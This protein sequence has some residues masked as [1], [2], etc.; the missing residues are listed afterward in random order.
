MPKI[1]FA[2]PLH[3]NLSDT[4]K[5]EL[6]SVGFEVI[7]ISFYGRK[8]TYTSL[9][10]R[11]INFLYKITGI[12]T[13]YKNHLIFRD[14]AN[15]IKNI[16]NDTGQVD[17]CFIIR[18]DVFPKEILK[19]AIEKASKSVAYQ[20]DGLNV[21][22]NTIDKINLFD[23]FYVF[24]KADLHYTNTKLS[25]NFYPESFKINPDFKKSD[26]YYTGTLN[27]SR[28]KTLE[29]IISTAEKAGLNVL[30]N[31]FFPKETNTKLTNLKTTKTYIDYSTNL[32]FV[33]NT[34]IVIDVLNPTH[35]G[36]SFRTFEAIGFKKKLITNNKSIQFY[37]FYHPNN[38]LIWD[39]TQNVDDILNFYNCPYIPLDEN[40]HAKYGFKNW[41]N[42][43]LDIQPH[44]SISNNNI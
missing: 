43:M 6:Q 21:Y 17:F 41:I 1:I 39:G 31:L 9:S 20:W 8:Y 28:L 38:I 40:I 14:H 10:D 16:L 15:R 26:L 44:I 5:R 42:Y 4:I 19:I 25:T 7:D 3:Y 29:E 11:I 24:D 27:K 13:A 35:N 18:P 33:T 37:D 30:Y 12:N 2:A 36:L 34:N 22:P 23:I 32:Q